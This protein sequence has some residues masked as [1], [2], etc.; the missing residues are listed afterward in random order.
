[1]TVKATQLDGFAIQMEALFRED[2]LSEAEP[3]RVLIECH[4]ALLQSYP[5]VV[6]LRGL[7]VPKFDA[8][9]LLQSDCVLR[10]LFCNR[11]GGNSMRTVG[12]DFF[13]VEQLDAQRQRLLDGF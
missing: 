4:P 9:E 8:L 6:Q 10:R 13:S 1:M 12:N 11:R 2:G 3:A 7:K 5:Y